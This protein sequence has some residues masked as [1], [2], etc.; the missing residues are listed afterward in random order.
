MELLIAPIFVMLTALSYRFRGLGG[1]PD[2]SKL[3]D[4]LHIRPIKLGQWGLL[5]AAPF[6]M[7]DLYYGLAVLLAMGA[8][9]APGHG[10]YFNLGRNPN[11][12]NAHETLWEWLTSRLV[13]SGMNRTLIEWIGL[14]CTGLVNG[15]PVLAAGYMM[16]SDILLIAALTVAMLIAKPIAYE[17]GWRTPVN[18]AF[19]EQGTGMGELYF[20]GLVGLIMVPMFIT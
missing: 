19:F 14:G 16:T 13:D 17:L 18:G 15:L 20:G 1:K 8:C 4:I 11:S 7:Y 10:A 12:Y 5:T 6:A 2:Q 3:Q 9:A